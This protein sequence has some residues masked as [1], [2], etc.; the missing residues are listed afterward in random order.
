MARKIAILGGTGA[1]GSGLAYR[2]AK[3]GEQVLIGSRDGAR[4]AET[5]RQ[6]CERIGGAAQIE[7]MDN[8]SAAAAMHCPSLRSAPLRQFARTTALPSLLP[9]PRHATQSAPAHPLSPS[10]RPARSLPP[11]FP[12]KSRFFA[13]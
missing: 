9:A 3:A 11:P 7:G 12:P 5:A 8:A 6:L 1:E 2:W 13:P 10:D 4:A